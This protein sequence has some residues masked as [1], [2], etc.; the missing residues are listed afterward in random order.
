M[1]KHYKKI[2]VGLVVVILMIL[3][4]ILNNQEKEVIANNPIEV[5]ET[6]NS[7]F[8]VDIKG[9]VKMPGVYEVD[10]NSRLQDIIKLA[11]GFTKE[12]RIDNL[13]LA[14]KITDEMV[15]YVDRLS[16]EEISSKV[17]INDASLA[18][19]DALNDV[20]LATAKK[21]IDYRT[22]NG[23]FH[24]LEELVTKDVISQALYSKIKEFI[25]L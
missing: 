8:M 9:E 10:S 19:L 18:E 4:I 24:T 20:G 23:P 17:S 6:N 11:G 2:I 3:G 22:K 14:Q 15:I 13:N 16:Y 7:R 12:A 25:C 5:L 21:I 1:K